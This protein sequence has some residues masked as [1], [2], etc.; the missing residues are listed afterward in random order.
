M[1]KP[2]GW[3]HGQ[4]GDGRGRTPGAPSRWTGA[5]D[6]TWIR[7]RPDLV[8]EVTFDYLQGDRFRHAATTSSA[9]GTTNRPRECG[10]DQLEVT[11]PFELSQVFSAGSKKS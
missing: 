10:F 5:R 11:T 4:E 9:G 7:L 8:C 2:A 6:M 3:A 1:K